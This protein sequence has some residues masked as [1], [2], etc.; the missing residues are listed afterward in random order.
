M[1]MLR[2]GSFSTDNREDWGK[3]K[4]TEAAL[5]SKKFAKNNQIPEVQEELEEGKK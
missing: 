1:P 5:A 4:Q 2:R 3:D